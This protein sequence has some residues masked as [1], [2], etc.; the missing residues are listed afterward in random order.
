[1]SFERTEYNGIDLVKVHGKWSRLDIDGCLYGK[2]FE[3]LDG[4]KSDVDRVQQG[5]ANKVWQ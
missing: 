2:R 1:M 4:L 3:T 5:I